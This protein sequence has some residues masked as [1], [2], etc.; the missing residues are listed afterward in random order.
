MP[1]VDVNMIP[2]TSIKF[3]RLGALK[4]DRATI[5]FQL[6]ITDIHSYDRQ[7]V[8]ILWIYKQCLWAVEFMMHTL[9]YYGQLR[10]RFSRFT[11]LTDGA[12]IQP[13]IWLLPTHM[14]HLKARNCVRKAEWIYH[15]LTTSQ[16]HETIFGKL[17]TF[18]F[19]LQI[20]LLLLTYLDQGIDLALPSYNFFVVGRCFYTL[21]SCSID[22][23]LNISF[24]FNH[25]YISCIIPQGQVRIWPS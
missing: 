8:Y 11:N 17:C 14:E 18:P 13:G 6:F 2:G 7:F 10:Y 16:E 1:H 25:R 15:R 9:F 24:A 3:P 12:F 23:V 4:L 22:I 21:F 19:R 20:E 5:Q